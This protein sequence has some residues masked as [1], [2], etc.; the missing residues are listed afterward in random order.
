MQPYQQTINW[1]PVAVLSLHSLAQ[2][3]L[4]HISF[5]MEKQLIILLVISTLLTFVHASKEDDCGLQKMWNAVK[6]GGGG[7]GTTGGAGFVLSKLGFT[8]AGVAKGVYLYISFIKFIYFLGSVA[9]W[10]Q[11]YILG[12]TVAKGSLF[13]VLQSA[14]AGGVWAGPV[15]AAGAVAGAAYGYYYVN[16][17]S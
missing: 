13:S 17:D 7:A 12:G 6:Y 4:A 8:A 11:S 9:S 16:C 15:G 1:Q 2:A 3:E 10:A 5:T 14:A